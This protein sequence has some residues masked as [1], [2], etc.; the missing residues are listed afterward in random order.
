MF[1]FDP[2]DPDRFAI[3]ALVRMLTSEITMAERH[4]RNMPAYEIKDY[5]I[6][7]LRWSAYTGQPIPKDLAPFLEWWY[8]QVEGAKH[9]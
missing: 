6:Q 1:G 7:I 9:G 8:N 5:L 3:N 4:I 2:K